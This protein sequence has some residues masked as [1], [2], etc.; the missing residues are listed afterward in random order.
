[1][2]FSVKYIPKK[3]KKRI[4]S[5]FSIVAKLPVEILDQY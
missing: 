4:V 2:A 3:K 5:P 1:M